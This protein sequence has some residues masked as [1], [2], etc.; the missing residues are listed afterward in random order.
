MTS[1]GQKKKGWRLDGHSKQK[2]I[3]TDSCQNNLGLWYPQGY[4]VSPTFFALNSVLKANA[5][6]ATQMISNWACYLHYMRSGCHLFWPS[7]KYPFKSLSVLMSKGCS[8]FIMPDKC[9]LDAWD[10]N[11]KIQ[12]C[13][14]LEPYCEH[15]WVVKRNI[16][17]V[18]CTFQHNILVSFI[19]F[20]NK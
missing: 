13:T 4:I 14:H 8:T 20:I 19:F 7:T 2:V 1:K 5:I 6:T 9:T 18:L 11:S 3:A 17:T 12:S 15:G 16:T 10:I